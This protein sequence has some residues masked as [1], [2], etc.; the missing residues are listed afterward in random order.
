MAANDDAKFVESGSFRVDRE[1]ALAK[2]E[3]YQLAD[4]WDFT[5]AWARLAVESGA[6]RVEVSTEGET[7]RLRF[8]GRPLPG[9]L[10]LDP[11]SGLFGEDA[12]GRGRLL[13]VGLLALQRLSPVS[14]ELRSGGRRWEHGL[15]GER[16]ER[17]SAE[18]GMSAQVRWQS[19][20]ARESAQRFL[21]EFKG[22]LSLADLE[23]VADGRSLGRRHAEGEAGA[24]K[25]ESLGRRVCARKGGSVYA[26]TVN[27]HHRGVRVYRAAEAALAGIEVHVQDDELPL[28][29]TGCRA[30][31]DRRMGDTFKLAEE[32]ALGLFPQ[33]PA[34]RR[35]R[36]RVSGHR[37][38][39][40]AVFLFGAGLLGY[41]GWN[42]SS[43]LFDSGHRSFSLFVMS[44]FLFLTVACAYFAYI[45]AR[46]D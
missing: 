36:L 10:L 31:W 12:D 3:R 7:S 17:V 32:A 20:S 30:V 26:G 40:V 24:R 16:A 28:D 11:V 37:P 13:A 39:D 4:P 25:T 33:P 34:P 27:V 23:V 6:S 44:A 42:T 1:K 41:L 9:G 19:A 22:A 29:F 2:L 21:Q 45:A 5:A 8:D 18:G 46:T 14:I 38:L 35:P 15:G 43:S